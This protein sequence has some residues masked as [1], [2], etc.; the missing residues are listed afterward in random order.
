MQT[1]P[2]D[3]ERIDREWSEYSITGEQM[4][5]II[6]FTAMAGALY[7]ATLGA[8]ILVASLLLMLANQPPLF[9]LS[10]IGFEEIYV[11]IMAGLFTG[12]VA[13]VV[14]VFVIPLTFGLFS[15]IYGKLRQSEV[16]AIAGGNVAAICMG[17]VILWRRNWRADDW[18]FEI[19]I[20]A[21]AIFM[22]QLGGRLGERQGR[23]KAWGSATLP[24]DWS[25][26]FTLRQLFALTTAICLATAG[27]KILATLNWQFA[28][29][30]VAAVLTQIV[31]LPVTSFLA[32]RLFFWPRHKHQSGGEPHPP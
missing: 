27:L 23:T 26:R 13:L 18:A 20:S 12:T 5:Y 30:L 28:F 3:P 19:A 8:L 22:G 17:F 31:L 10:N 6:L 16:A 4:I 7:P 1:D 29:C 32:T 15:P 25:W 24:A 2:Q 11:P 9:P 21:L 14:C